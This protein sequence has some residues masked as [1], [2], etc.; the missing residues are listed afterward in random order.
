VQ[1]ECVQEALEHVHAQ[2]HRKS[3]AREG[4]VRQKDHHGVLGLDAHHHGFLPKH[5]RKLGVSQTQ[6]PEP[7]VR[8]SVGDHP[9]HELNGF[10]ALVNHDF[11]EVVLF[12]AVAT[13]AATVATVAA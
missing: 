12:F 2:Q 1:P 3:H 6:G 7:E 4:T 10:N 11:G 8:G 9:Q 13:A 5:R